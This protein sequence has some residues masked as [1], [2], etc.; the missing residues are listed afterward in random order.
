M[1]TVFKIGYINH[2]DT[3]VLS[4]SGQVGTKPVTLLVDPHPARRWS[5]GLT[6]SAWINMA[7]AEPRPIDC[8][9]LM[10]CSHSA[11][12]RCRVTA[13]D[14]SGGT[15]LY[16]SGDLPAQVDPRFGYLIHVLPAPVTTRSVRLYLTDPS[17]PEVRGGRLFAGPLWTPQYG[18]TVGLEFGRAPLSTQTVGRA[19]QTFIDRRGNPRATSFTLGVVT[20]AEE[21]THLREMQRLCANS[22]DMLVIFDTSDPNPGDVSIWGIA[23]D[24]QRPRRDLPR[25]HSNAFAIT[26]RL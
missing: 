6:T 8:V 7:W 3:A 15:D 24:L 17:V 9:A 1:N 21:R 18:P 5:A 19:G 11:A 20:L 23:K 25:Y 26:E 12:G 10:G 13:S 2:A 22:D 14:S 16:D 4:A